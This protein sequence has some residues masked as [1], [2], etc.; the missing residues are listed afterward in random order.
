VRSPLTIK[1]VTPIRKLVSPSRL[2]PGVQASL[3][4]ARRKKSSSAIV[5][6]RFWESQDHDSLGEPRK[7]RLNEVLAEAL[8]PR[9]SVHGQR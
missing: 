2:I 6:G 8:V 4:G 5:D 7:R 1:A 9:L 3:D